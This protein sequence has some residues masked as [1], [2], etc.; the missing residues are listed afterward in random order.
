MIQTILGWIYKILNLAQQ[1]RVLVH[2]AY[3]SSGTDCYFINVTNRSPSRDAEVT[4]VWFA[5][6]PDIHVLN[7]QR[8][9][10]RR[11][12]PEESWETWIEVNKFP[13]TI[14]ENAFT[15]A[16]VRL[17]NGRVINSKRNTNVPG[18]GYIPGG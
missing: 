4:H 11:L 8:P 6:N 9:L 10:P 1:V 17:S 5:C 12:R 18:E 14:R 15:F 2:R 13:D 7:H 3:L 16:R